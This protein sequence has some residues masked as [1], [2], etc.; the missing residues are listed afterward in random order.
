MNDTENIVE[1]S[2]PPA[3][4]SIPYLSG[5]HEAML[6]VSDRPVPLTRLREVF[7]EK[8][9]SE[10]E[11]LEAL[12]SLRSRYEDASSGFELRE[13][14]GGYHFVTKVAHAEW[15]RKF[16]ATRPFR[17]GRSTLETLAIIS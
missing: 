3:E 15:V 5:A 8:A 10:T 11:L 1:P 13:A 12:G 2:T 7:G 4:T 9:P 16:L 14:Q 17:L 6:F